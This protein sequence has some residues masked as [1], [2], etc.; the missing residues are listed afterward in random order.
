MTTER[1]D[2]ARMFFARAWKRADVDIRDDEITAMWEQ[3]KGD[4]NDLDARRAYEDADT[5]LAWERRQR[6][7][8]NICWTASFVPVPGE[9]EC[10][11]AHPHEGEHARCDICWLT[12]QHRQVLTREAGLR[13]KLTGLGE[14]YQDALRES[15][16]MLADFA[17]ALGLPT[18]VGEAE[19]PGYPH[20]LAAIRALRLLVA[21]LA[22]ALE[23]DHSRQTV[24]GPAPGCCHICALLA[25]PLVVACR[26]EEG[27]G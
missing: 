16:E 17:A 18:M 4:P 15:D 9:S 19:A 5:V 22:G 27:K 11:L 20:V 23:N 6:M 25:D 10:V 2:V 7:V 3:R 26:E 14:I 13:E 12:E 1:E 8:C 24:G 21:R